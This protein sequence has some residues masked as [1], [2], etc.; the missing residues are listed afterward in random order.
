M[1][2]ANVALF[3]IEGKPRVPEWVGYLAGLAVTDLDAMAT[4]SAGA[5][6]FLSPGGAD[7]PTYACTWG[8][9]H[10]H[11]NKRLITPDL[12]LRV[13][14]NL[15]AEGS[16]QA[17][18]DVPRVRSTQT[19]SLAGNGLLSATQ[20]SRELGIMS[21]PVDRR[22][23]VIRGI[24]AIPIDAD[25]WG[26]LVTGATAI[27]VQRPA[28]L[29]AMR[30]LC[31]DIEAK[32]H[33][34]DYR[35]RYAWIDDLRPVVDAK[36]RRD[37]VDHIVSLVRKGDE[38]IALSP[39]TV[40]E[41]DTVQSFKFSFDDTIFSSLPDCAH[42]R[43]LLTTRKQLNTLDTDTVEADHELLGIDESG[44]VSQAWSVLECLSAT[45][46]ISGTTYVLEGGS[47]YQVRREFVTDRKS[48]V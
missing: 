23:D 24:T 25:K 22:N 35:Q 28:T 18:W 20:A 7:N 43:D 38:A 47:V 1:G 30:T 37:V 5:V 12:G 46:T 8:T 13:A 36:T 44:E 19:K 48:V 31:N 32:Y 40:I 39:A 9:G 10:L 6:L 42:Y 3:M 29:S 45:V 26:R 21:F 17:L 14:F 27:Q 34:L 15:I 11:L 2:D 33:S 41:W 4:A 16:V